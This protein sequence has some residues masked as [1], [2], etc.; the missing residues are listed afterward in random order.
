MM[1]ATWVTMMWKRAARYST[2][3]LVLVT[4]PYWVPISSIYRR[5]RPHLPPYKVM[6]RDGVKIV[7]LGMITPCYPGMALGEPV[8]GAAFRRHGGDGTQVDEDHP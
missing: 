5:E 8:E 3:G 7:V 2:V 4:F 1:P 6:E